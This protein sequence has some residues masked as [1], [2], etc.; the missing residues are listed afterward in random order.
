MRVSNVLHRLEW[1][2]TLGLMYAQGN[3]V[4][5]SDIEAVKWFTKAAEQGEAVAQ[6]NLGSM[7]KQGRGVEQS[8]VEA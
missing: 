4:E 8:I 1:S 7:Y 3:G 2:I 5:Q 6:S